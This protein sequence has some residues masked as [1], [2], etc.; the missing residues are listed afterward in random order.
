MNCPFNFWFSYFQWFSFWI[1]VH[2]ALLI[3]CLVLG[4]SLAEPICEKL[5]R[6]LTLIRTRKKSWWGRESDPV[7]S[8]RHELNE[9]IWPKHLFFF[10]ADGHA[11]HPDHGHDHEHRTSINTEAS[12]GAAPVASSYDAQPAYSP[13]APAYSQPAPSY[14]PSQQS[15]AQSQ[16]AYTPSQPSYSQPQ[17]SYGVPS[18]SYGAPKNSCHRAPSDRAYPSIVFWWGL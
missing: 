2:Q 18:N 16:Q 12:A 14:N 4:A 5:S 10:P 7:Y 3:L 17:Q 1:V 13:S 11:H 8:L 6:K 15:Y 9:I